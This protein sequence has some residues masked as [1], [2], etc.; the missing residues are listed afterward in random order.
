MSESQSK[1]EIITHSES[2]EFTKGSDQQRTESYGGSNENF[3][4]TNQ[5]EL[6]YTEFDHQSVLDC[7]ASASTIDSYNNESLL[8]NKSEAVK[9]RKNI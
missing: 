6:K 1:E 5:K 4:E 3:K 8:S 2:L 9:S 7:R